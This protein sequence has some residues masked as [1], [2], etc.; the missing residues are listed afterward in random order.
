MAKECVELAVKHRDHRF[1]DVPEWAAE[2]FSKRKTLTKVNK[3]RKK[4]KTGDYFKVS[5][6][7]L[8][9]DASWG[10]LASDGVP[11]PTFECGDSEHHRVLVCG[12]RKV[13]VCRIMSPQWTGLT[14]KVETVGSRHVALL[15][16]PSPSA[17]AAH[18]RSAT[19]ACGDTK[20]HMYTNA[21]VLGKM[22]LLAAPI[23]VDL[24]EPECVLPLWVVVHSIQ[25]G[26]QHQVLVKSRKAVARHRKEIV[27]DTAVW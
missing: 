24:V 10:R 25:W 11:L 19:M 5:T 12:G 23:P 8:A 16:V 15:G 1:Y 27:D 9:L 14:K 2:E 22:G 18:V 6:I 17:D 13:S 7:A 21:V 26:R 20:L 4:L 3:V